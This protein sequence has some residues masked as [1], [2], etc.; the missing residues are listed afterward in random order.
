MEDNE[1]R[2]GYDPPFYRY[3][4][5]PRSSRFCAAVFEFLWGDFP[6]FALDQSQGGLKQAPKQNFDDVHVPELIR[7]HVESKSSRSYLNRL[8]Y[9][10]D[11]ARD[12]ISCHLSRKSSG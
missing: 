2:A 1:A 11:T 10:V 12:L 3:G 8:S 6:D 9:I 4:L 5:L 7:M